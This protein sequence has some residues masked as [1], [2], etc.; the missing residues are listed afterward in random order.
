[1]HSSALRC[2]QS[3]VCP[4]LLV[5][6]ATLSLGLW[7]G[8]ASGEDK[9]PLSVAGYRLSGSAAVGYRFVEIDSGSKD[10]YHEVV[11]LEEGV[12][13]FNF[14]LHGDRLGSEAKLVDHVSLEATDIGDPYPKIQ[15]HVAKDEVYK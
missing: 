1:M 2:L 6:L 13:L 8:E 14:T 3:S 15:F 4:T 10:F 12:R 11:N 5:L 9:L 7:G